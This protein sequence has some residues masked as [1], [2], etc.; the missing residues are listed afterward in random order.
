[1]GGKWQMRP[2]IEGG[3]REGAEGEV[4]Q[5]K[6]SIGRMCYNEEEINRKSGSRDETEVGAEDVGTK[7]ESCWGVC[8]PHTGVLLRVFTEDWRKA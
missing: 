1:M 3:K 6:N 2:T 5:S 7:Y 8:D 4:G